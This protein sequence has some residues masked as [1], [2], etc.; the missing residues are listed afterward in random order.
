M[1]YRLLLRFIAACL[2]VIA[3]RTG[4]RAKLRF[5]RLS[6]TAIALMARIGF[7]RNT[8]HSPGAATEWSDRFPAPWS[9]PSVWP[10]FTVLRRARDEAAASLCLRRCVVHWTTRPVRPRRQLRCAPLRKADARQQ[11]WK[12]RR[13]VCGLNVYCQH[14]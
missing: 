9:R 14:P 7:R 11:V 12:S 3:T 1:P 10:V 6:T 4:G 5:M 2:P 8:D 13:A